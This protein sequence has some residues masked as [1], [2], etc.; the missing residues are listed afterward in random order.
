MTPI[1]DLNAAVAALV[2]QDADLQAAIV[3]EDSAAIEAAAS[4][5][6]STTVVLKTAAAGIPVPAAPVVA[7]V[8]PV[9]VQTYDPDSKLPLYAFVGSSR[10]IDALSWVP[11]S[12]VT[13]PHGL[14]LFTYAE[15]KA[16]EEP[17]GTGGEFEPY[18][19]E[20]WSPGPFV[21]PSPVFAGPS[22]ELSSD[23]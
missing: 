22:I 17:T 13:G 11:V 7:P 8:V 14:R 2:A 9:L 20:L 10:T 18:T 4:R 16:G 6:S 19:G 21:V 3:A 12:D 5:I 1:L 15:D 23:R